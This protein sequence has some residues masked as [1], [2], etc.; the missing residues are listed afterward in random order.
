MTDD[1]A[2]DTDPAG[3]LTITWSERRRSEEAYRAAYSGFSYEP[4]PPS[5]RPGTPHRFFIESYRVVCKQGQQRGETEES[6]DGEEDGDKSD[7]I[8]GRKSVVFPVI[9]KNANG[10]VVVTVGA[11]QEEEGA[12]SSAGNS[13]SYLTAAVLERLAGVEVVAS[14]SLTDSRSAKRRRQSKMLRGK[15]QAELGVVR[16]DDVLAVLD[17]QIEDDKKDSRRDIEKEDGG[18]GRSSAGTQKQHLDV[19]CGV[20]GT[21]IEVNANLSPELV[22]RDSALDGFLAIVL[23]TGPFPPPQVTSASSPPNRRNDSCGS[24]QGTDDGEPYMLL[25]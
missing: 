7:V 21:V 1:S 11:K 10:L 14:A 3:P 24:A 4:L 15:S 13:A 2:T 12:S 23:P 6:Q 20:W 5:G 22:R 8:G 18:A 17:F 25:P 19:L 16:P 9:H